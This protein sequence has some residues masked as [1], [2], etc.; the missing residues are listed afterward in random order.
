MWYKFQFY[1]LKHQSVR[2]KIEFD[3]ENS[4]S[5]LLQCNSAT[6]YRL[7]RY[8]QFT[9]HFPCIYTALKRFFQELM[10]SLILSSPDFEN[11]GAPIFLITQRKMQQIDS[12]IE[13]RIH[14][15]LEET[16][17][18]CM[19]RKNAQSTTCS[20][21]KRQHCYIAT[22]RNLNFR[23]Q[24]LFLL[25]QTSALSYKTEIFNHMLTISYILCS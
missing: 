1:N 12:G 5:G 4:N 2:A 17:E 23:Y 9:V 25:I 18:S 13:H 11:G 3:A 8:M 14:C 10:K 19:Q 21:G 6:Y 20:N 15:F 7:S 24:I 16:F 22:V